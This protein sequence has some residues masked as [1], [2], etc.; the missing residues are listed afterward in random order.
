MKGTAPLSV[1]GANAQ[2]EGMISRGTSF[3][4]VE[5]AIEAAEFPPLHKAALWLLAWSL[6]EPGIQRH[7]ARRMAEA[8]AAE[9]W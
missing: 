1:D 7:D 4:R 5:A 2:V 8:F 9:G 3:A 6:R